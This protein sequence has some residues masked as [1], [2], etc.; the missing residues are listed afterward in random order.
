MVGYDGVAAVALSIRQSSGR[1]FSGLVTAAQAAII[2]EVWFRFT[3]V[4]PSNHVGR[5]NWEV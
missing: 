3:D 2:E 4:P 5:F 1:Q